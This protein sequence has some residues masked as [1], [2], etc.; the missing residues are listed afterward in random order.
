PRI[1]IPERDRD[2]LRDFIVLDAHI[3]NHHIRPRTVG[4]PPGDPIKMKSASA[5]SCNPF[6]PSGEKG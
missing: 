5:C 1:G 6:S 3:F 4:F 2:V